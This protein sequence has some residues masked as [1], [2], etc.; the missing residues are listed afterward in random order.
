MTNILMHGS[1][2]QL[3]FIYKF[4]ELESFT[5]TYVTLSRCY[6]RHAFQTD[7]RERVTHTL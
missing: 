3:S 2:S 1:V 5:I 4:N 7:V 6:A